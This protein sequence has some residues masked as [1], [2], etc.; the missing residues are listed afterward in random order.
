MIAEKG[1]ELI[2]RAARAG[3]PEITVKAA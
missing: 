3:Q 1:A 2:R